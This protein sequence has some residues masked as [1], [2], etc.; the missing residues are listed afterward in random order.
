[1][2]KIINGRAMTVPGETPT[3]RR[4]KG[5]ATLGE[6]QWIAKCPRCGAHAKKIRGGWQCKSASCDWKG[7]EVDV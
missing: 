5:H 6:G 4:K 7:K 2:K 3:V 1:V